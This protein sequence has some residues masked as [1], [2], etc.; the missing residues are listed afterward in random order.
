MQSKR[1]ICL[2]NE[3]EIKTILDFKEYYKIKNG[4]DLSRNAIIKMLV[5]KLPNEMQ[6]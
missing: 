4:I 3:A 2:L 6:Q 1:I 5:R